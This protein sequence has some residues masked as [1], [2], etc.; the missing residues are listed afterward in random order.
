MLPK[1]PPR[2]GQLGF[3]YIPPYRIYGVSVAGESTAVV[4]PELDVCFDIGVCLRPMLSPANVALTH[5]HMD[6]V[7][8]LPYYFSQRWFQGMGT[9]R[10]ICDRRIEPAVRRMMEGWVDLEQQRTPH[11]IVGLEAEQDFE[12]K[13]NIFIRGFHVDHTVPSMGFTVLERRTKLKAEFHNLPQEKLMEIKRGGTEITREIRVPLVTYIG[14]ILPGPALMRE[15]V[16]NS[17]VVIMEC[18]FFEGDHRDRAL[19]GQHVHVS[20]IAEL[21]P[22]LKADA[23]ILTHVSRRTNLGLAREQLSARIG[24]ANTNRVFLLMDHRENR[25]RYEAQVAAGEVGKAEAGED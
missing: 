21:F 14:D 11:E 13:N 16:V 22:R 7:A 19:T 5:G 6:H 15:D 23:L 1:A 9:G 17:K 12:I 4:V 24:E 20:D 25:K 8:G 18:T 2:L 3:L 10:C